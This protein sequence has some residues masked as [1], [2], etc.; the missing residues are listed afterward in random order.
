MRHAW[1]VIVVGAG[2]AGS[3][4][5]SLFG[6]Q[7]RRVLL[8]DAARFP[9]SKPCAEYVSPGGAAILERLGALDRLHARRWLR[10][11]EIQAPNGFCHLVDYRPA[12]GAQR[13]GLSVQRTLLDATLLSVARDHGAE[14]REGFR[15]RS[16]VR[17]TGRVR[18]IIGPSGERFDAELVVG[19]DGLHSIVSR[20]V[21]A[22]RPAHWPRRLGLVA[23]FEGVSWHEDYG[24]MLVGRRGY[25]GIAPLDDTGL[26][27]VGLVRSLPRGRLGSPAAALEAGL[28][29]YPA[30]LARLKSG[31]LASAVM[32]V[33]PLASRVGTCA[34]PGFA[35]V[36]DAAGFFDPFTGEG[37]YR[38]LRG[39]ELLASCPAAYARERAHV[40]GSKERLVALI[41]L[42][43]QTPF[44]MNRAIDRLR[45]RPHVARALG[46]ALGDLEPAR[47][48]LAWQLFG[49]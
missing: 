42:F 9:R 38:A 26:I 25:V 32:G 33:G 45:R 6:Q 30:A 27:T 22:R 14:T 5:A 17:E 28:A 16:I 36:G 48:G 39:A 12:D 23:H 34:G 31:R 8:V 18:G 15:V 44:L 1:D 11:M 46:C 7:G 4:A 19:A 24:R 37:I 21:G 40:F 49:P 41:Q 47:L 20:A 3:A 10:G 29:D 2:P 43:V 35:L 13:F